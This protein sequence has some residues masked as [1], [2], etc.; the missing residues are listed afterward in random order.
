LQL[1]R[2]FVN[3][4]FF[5]DAG[6]TKAL[7]MFPWVDESVKV[8]DKRAALASL[9]PVDDDADED[10]RKIAETAPPPREKVADE[11]RRERPDMGFFAAYDSDEGSESASE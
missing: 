7:W 5:A 11:H 6:S 10:E 1:F 4:D 3:N 9:P 2:F 8:V